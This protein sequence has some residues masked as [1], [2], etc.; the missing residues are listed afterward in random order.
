VRARREVEG[1]IDVS[2]PIVHLDTGYLTLVAQSALP[3][4]R[5]SATPIRKRF[6]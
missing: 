5:C 4:R 2:L 1:V 6:T 3:G